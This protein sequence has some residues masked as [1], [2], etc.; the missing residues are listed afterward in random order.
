MSENFKNQA[1][2]NLWKILTSFQLWV[3]TK[4]SE[5]KHTSNPNSAQGVLK[6]IRMIDHI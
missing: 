3:W 5:K 6:P 1:K 4:Q 2:V